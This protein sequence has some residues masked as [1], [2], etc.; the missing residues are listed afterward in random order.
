MLATFSHYAVGNGLLA[1]FNT[2][3]ISA[4]KHH[5][6]Y[7]QTITANLQILISA[8]VWDDMLGSAILTVKHN[9]CS[10]IST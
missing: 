1:I 7:S 9:L 4:I 8:N 5:H 2:T 10:I 6:Y 3:Y